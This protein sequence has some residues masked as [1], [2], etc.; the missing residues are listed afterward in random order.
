MA[1]GMGMEDYR[2]MKRECSD[3]CSHA[4]ECCDDCREWSPTNPKIEEE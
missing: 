1:I 3:D 4:A 2:D